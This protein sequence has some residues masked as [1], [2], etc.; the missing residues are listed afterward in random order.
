[1]IAKKTMKASSR[2]ERAK[3]VPVKPDDE[4]ANKRFDKA[5]VA[6]MREREDL[7]SMDDA[8]ERLLDDF[9]DQGNEIDQSLFLQ[10][11]ISD[12]ASLIETEGEAIERRYKAIEGNLMLAAFRKRGC[13]LDRE[14]YKKDVIRMYK[15]YAKIKKAGNVTGRPKDE[16]T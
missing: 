16:H 12:P 15:R 3:K 4:I 1:M 10:D 7:V 13:K 14:A 9:P 6:I 2:T 5:L 8:L 11:L